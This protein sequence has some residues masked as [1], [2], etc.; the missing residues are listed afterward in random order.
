[1]EPEDNFRQKSYSISDILDNKRNKR[2]ACSKNAYFSLLV[3]DA[4]CG[5]IRS[6][7]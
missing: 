3:Y 1:M 5:P 6:R 4:A 7:I 2:S